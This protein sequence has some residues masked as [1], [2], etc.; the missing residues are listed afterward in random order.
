M[1]DGG[2]KKVKRGHFP[3]PKGSPFGDPGQNHGASKTSHAGKGEFAKTL[4]SYVDSMTVVPDSSRAGDEGYYTDLRAKS[5]NLVARTT[6]MIRAK[7]MVYTAASLAKNPQNQ[8]LFKVYDSIPMDWEVDGAN[9]SS[10]YMI[11]PTPRRI[12]ANMQGSTPIF[13]NSSFSTK[14]DMIA[15]GFNYEL[16]LELS[17]DEV[18]EIQKTLTELSDSFASTLQYMLVQKLLMVRNDPVELITDDIEK[19]TAALLDWNEQCWARFN[20]GD[21]NSWEDLM[22]MSQE[23]IREKL[24]QRPIYFLASTKHGILSSLSEDSTLRESGLELATKKRQRNDEVVSTLTDVTCHTLELGLAVTGQ[25]H[26]LA[27]TITI[28]E[29]VIQRVHQDDMK[30]MGVWLA[31]I[32][33]YEYITNREFNKRLFRLFPAQQYQ[34][35]TT[36]AA[37]AAGV[38]FKGFIKAEANGGDILAMY[39]SGL[40]SGKV[41]AADFMVNLYG[42]FVTNGSLR[43][44]GGFDQE[45]VPITTGMGLSEEALPTSMIVSWVKKVLANEEKRRALGTEMIKSSTRYLPATVAQDQI[46][47]ME[48]ILRSRNGVLMA[49]AKMPMVYLYQ[50]VA[51]DLHQG[52]LFGYT[53]FGAASTSPVAPW[54]HNPQGYN[55]FVAGISQKLSSLRKNAGNIFPAMS[56]VMTAPDFILASM[57]VQLPDVNNYAELCGLNLLRDYNS[58]TKEAAKSI[59][60]NMFTIEQARHTVTPVAVAPS[61]YLQTLSNTLDAAVLGMINFHPNPTEAD[62]LA[63]DLVALIAAAVAIRYTLLAGAAAP[64]TTVPY[65]ATDNT[66]VLIRAFHT[67]NPGSLAATNPI[68]ALSAYF[69]YSDAV[70]NGITPSAWFLN[71]KAGGYLHDL[72]EMFG[73]LIDSEDTSNIAAGVAFGSGICVLKDLENRG[74]FDVGKEIIEGFYGYDD[75]EPTTEIDNRKVSIRTGASSYTEAAVVVWYLKQSFTEENWNMFDSIGLNRPYRIGIWTFNTQY[76]G[77]HS[78]ATSPKIGIFGTTDVAPQ[79]E[80]GNGNYNNYNRLVLKYLMM[81]TK[82]SS[83]L[84]HR[85]SALTG[86]RKQSRRVWFEPDVVGIIRSPQELTFDPLRLGEKEAFLFPYLMCW[87]ESDAGKRAS[88]TGQHWWKSSAVD[89]SVILD[90]A[91]P[92]YAFASCVLRRYDQQFINARANMI[93]PPQGAKNEDAVGTLDCP[94]IGYHVGKNYIDE[95]GDIHEDWFD[96]LFP[97]SYCAPGTANRR[98]KVRSNATLSN[99]ITISNKRQKYA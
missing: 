26:V 75:I 95:K 74:H 86:Y 39:N 91:E 43:R 64:F 56:L 58:S 29:V 85:F 13:G 51:T 28:P 76:N 82:Q 17:P 89:D 81:I 2:V 59:I 97:A 19:S 35:R 3:F 48:M 23:H 22:T 94:F 87:G 96:S 30:Q 21:K 50:V 60:K 69:S 9:I 99:N 84:T 65:A 6:L 54:N 34:S 80:S 38:V 62:N 27:D 37:V 49:L 44:A 55:T 5:L 52:P 7:A 57:R 70:K 78:I 93:N 41:S 36:R 98:V 53:G 73:E 14:S 8:V 77:M 83:V 42:K 31:A 20:I 12:G 72:I 25:G 46:S 90:N 15:L 11:V 79:K 10:R 47:T 4:S 40:S 63:A 33:G 92:G 66:Q 1:S 71:Y 68:L 16:N 32:D 18:T 88:F 61:L 45:L 24:G 67:A